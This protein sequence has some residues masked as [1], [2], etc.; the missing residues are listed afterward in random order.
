VL[1]PNLICYNKRKQKSTSRKL[2]LGDFGVFSASFQVIMFKS[3]AYLMFK[4]E[5]VSSVF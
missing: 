5:I 2:E 3:K 4:N 1:K